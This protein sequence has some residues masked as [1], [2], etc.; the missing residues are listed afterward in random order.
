MN[1][2]SIDINRD[3]SQMHT[4]WALYHFLPHFDRQLSPRG[5][6]AKYREF[7]YQLKH[8]SGIMYLL[9]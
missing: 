7:I 8:L 3:K 2:H 5:T 6:F 4:S 1:C 9:L